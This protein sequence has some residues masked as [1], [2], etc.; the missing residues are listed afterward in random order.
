MHFL[1]GGAY[2]GVVLGCGVTAQLESTHNAS[3]IIHFFRLNTRVMYISFQC[4]CVS[5]LYHIH[6]NIFHSSIAV[7]LLAI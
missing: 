1:G 6:Y 4:Y 2:L 3:N 5:L 7:F